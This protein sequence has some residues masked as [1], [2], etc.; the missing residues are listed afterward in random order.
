MIFFEDDTSFSFNTSPPQYKE[1]LTSG[2]W[3]ILAG[4]KDTPPHIALINEAKYYSL[5][6]RK[7]DCGSPLEKFMNAIERKHIPSLFVRLE[8]KKNLTFSLEKFYKDL[9]PLGS[10]ENTCISPI[11]DLFA[12]YYSPEFASVDYVFE[13]LALAE[14][15]KIL[16]ECISPLC[17]YTCTN[18]VTLPKY[19]ITQIRNKIEAL[20][21]QFTSFK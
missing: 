20:S 19:N 16:I 2:L 21:S 1:V 3:L 15:K 4:I 18:I 12:E 9:P 10:N 8:T 7:V 14:K 5:S 11:K 17:K 6:T 13:L